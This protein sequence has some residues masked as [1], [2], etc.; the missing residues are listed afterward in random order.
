MTERFSIEINVTEQH[1]RSG[2]L[3]EK[4]GLS[5]EKWDKWEP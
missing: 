1:L 2:T 3:Y 4:T 5:R